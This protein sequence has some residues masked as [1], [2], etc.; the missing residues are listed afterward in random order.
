MISTDTIQK[1]IKTLLKKAEANEVHW[2][3]SDAYHVTLDKHANFTFSF[4]KSISGDAVFVNLK[5]FSQN[6]DR[7]FED[8]D[9]CKDVSQ[10][11]QY[12]ESYV[13][14]KEDK[15][16]LEVI[17]TIE[18]TPGVVGGMWESPRP[19]PEQVKAFFEQIAGRWKFQEDDI[20]ITKNG[21]LTYPNGSQFNLYLSW[22]NA[23]FSRVEMCRRHP[24][25]G[26][27][28][29]I[30]VLSVTPNEMKGYVKH[31]EAKIKYVRKQE[32]RWSFWGILGK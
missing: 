1:L 27:V 18:F 19:K 9:I 24:L 20:E 31:N 15:A 17:E 25:T 29:Q 12:A 3:F 11:I 13:N 21:I 16:L 5:H 23:D 26:K 22:C 28:H 2:W 10:L 7:R 6:L 30:E 4:A 32:P 8:E 14:Q